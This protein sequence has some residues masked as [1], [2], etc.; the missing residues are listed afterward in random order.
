MKKIISVF[1]MALI[2]S[3]CQPPDTRDTLIVTHMG[4]MQSLDPVFSYDGVTQGMMLNVY[5]TLLK[6]NGSSMTDFL[7]SELL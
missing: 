1:I 7:P 2:L 3:A 4:E 6:F 5:D